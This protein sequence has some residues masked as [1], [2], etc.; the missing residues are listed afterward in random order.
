LDDLLERCE[1]LATSD[2]VR[3]EIKLWVDAAAESVCS[4]QYTN[5]GALAP[6][7]LAGKRTKADT[8]VPTPESD[9]ELGSEADSNYASQHDVAMT[10]SGESPHNY[11]FSGK[12]YC[13]D[14]KE[15]NDAEYDYNSCEQS[16]VNQ[17]YELA[18]SNDS[19]GSR[20]PTQ[21]TMVTPRAYAGSSSEPVGGL[22]GPQ[23]VASNIIQAGAR[24]QPAQQ[25]D[26]TH[27]SSS[28][29]ILPTP[30]E[31]P[32]QQMVLKHGTNFTGA[33]SVVNGLHRP[34]QGYVPVQGRSALPMSSTTTWPGDV[35]A[36]PTM[37]CHQPVLRDP[38]ASEPQAMQPQHH[39]QCAGAHNA[40]YH[41]Q[42]HSTTYHGDEMTTD[43]HHNGYQSGILSDP[44]PGGILENS[45]HQAAVVRYDQPQH[46]H[47]QRLHH[48]AQSPV[49]AALPAYGTRPFHLDHNG[50]QRARYTQR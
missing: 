39:Y 32:A 28:R 48:Q 36:A 24:Y 26:Q 34:H 16:V 2:E 19:K 6:A 35:R 22:C 33:Q 20:D 38:Y 5:I 10:E 21:T 43:R 15:N 13:A 9:A 40:G 8:P 44:Y 42:P 14:V 1:K 49:S 18:A 46:S 41:S 45:H 27:N 11:N 29:A 30:S 17:P 12:E 37:Y 7:L 31:S 50:W 47:A 4:R 3:S 25:Q 23:A